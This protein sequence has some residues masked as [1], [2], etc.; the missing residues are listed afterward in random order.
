ELATGDGVLVLSDFTSLDG[1]PLTPAQL[2]AEYGLHEG[3]TLPVLEPAE[4]AAAEEY[5]ALITKHE[6]FWVER[7]SR[8]LSP[9]LS[10]LSPRRGG[11]RTAVLMRALPASL[12]RLHADNERQ[13]CALVSALAAYLARVSDGSCFDLALQQTRVAPS[14]TAA[15]AFS[16]I[17]PLR[18]DVQLEA[19]FASLVEDTRRELLTVTKRRTFA[20]D[21]VQRYQVLRGR[22][23]V[24]RGRLPIGVRL[25]ADEPPALVEGTQ[26]SLLRTADARRYAWA[27]DADAISAEAI[28][29]LAERFE[30]LLA[31]GLEDDR[32]PVAE[33]AI[34]PAAEREQLLTSW[35]RT[36]VV[37]P[38]TLCVHQLFEQQ[39]A[40]TPDARAVAFRAE[41]LSYRE[42]NQRANRVAEHLR[43]LGVE[44]ETLVGICVDRSLDMIIGLL[45]I[46]KAGGAY[47]PL[48]PVYPR[49]RLALML[50][51]ANAR[52]L[53][54]QRQWVDRLP[55]HSAQVLCIDELELRADGPC[56]DPSSSVQPDNL[57]YVIFTSGSTGRP[58]G[59]MVRHRN[60]VNFFAGMDAAL[61]TDPGVWLAV[62]SMSFDISV[63][64]LFWTLARG[65][66]VVIQE[67]S[68]RASLA[69]PAQVRRTHT[70]MDFGLF[71]FAADSGAAHAGNAYKLLLEG[72]KFA[73]SHDFSAVWT[74]E[75][76]FHAFGGLYPNPAVTTAALAT[77]TSRIQLR[78]GSVVLP[79]HNPLRVAE[80]WAVVDQ[81]S[82][83]R[84]G[85]SF[86]SGWHVNDFALMPE[87]FERRREIMLEHIDTVLKLWRGDK[88]T[89]LNGQGAPIEVSVLPRPVQTRPPLWIA[90]AGSVATFELAGKL[91]VNVLTNMLGQDLADLQ[92]KLAAYRAA[93]VEHGHEGPGHVSVMLHTFVCGDTDEAKRLV[94]KPFC[95]YLAS[96]FDLVKVA[97]WMFPAFRQPSVLA[98]RAAQPSASTTTVSDAGIDPS[99]YTPE[100]MAALLD[101]A[102]ER[103]F[104]SAGLFGTPERALAIVDQLKAIGANEVACLIDFG[105]DPDLVLASLPHLDRLR[106]LANPSVSSDSA[107]LASGGFSIGEQLRDRKIT[108]LQCTPSMARMLVADP[109]TLQGLRGLSRLLLG[110]EALPTD[111]V[112]QLL[113]VVGGEI[114]N[115]YG[116][117]ETTVWSTTS[118]VQSAGNIT[119]GRPIANTVTRILDARR[120]LLPI[121]A[122]GE[123]CIGGDGVVRGYLGRPDLTAERFIPDPFGREHDLLYRTG[124][125]ARYRADGTLEFRGRLDH[126]VKVSG[127]RIEL[128]E[129]ETVL[130]RHPAVRQCVVVAR[131]ED[132]P[133]QLVGYVVGAGPEAT[134]ATKVEA[135]GAAVREQNQERVSHWQS[136]WDQTYR[137]AVPGEHDARFNITGWNDS[138]TGEPIPR[139]QMREWLDAT[140]RRIR[141]FAPK[142]VLEIGCGTGMV[143]Y[144]VVPHVEHY[145]GVDLS[146][147]ALDT[148]RREL[149]ASESAKVTLLQQAA[150]TLDGVAE[151]TFDT[152]VINSVVQYFPDADYLVQVLRRASELVADGGRIF[153]GDVRSLEHLQAF[154]TWVELKQAPS[155][156]NAVEIAQRVE[157]RVANER[158]LVLSESFFHAL[159][160]S[161]PRVVAVDVRLKPGAAHNEMNCFRY[162]VTLHI[163]SALGA[164][165]V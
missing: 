82:G 47:V 66:E 24:A 78:A 132:G 9:T 93:R 83:G 88:V 109:M 157:Q 51:D 129:I 95:D 44:P 36:E 123:L 86:A 33:L 155:H 85:L 73:D 41:S 80:D 142:R 107:A 10:E 70:R 6:R 65:F 55:A 76:H 12:L 32:R 53:I 161:V 163:G 140:L 145:T 158:E 96:S 156:V 13:K 162:D 130:R 154:H 90:S 164:D 117:T 135:R 133:A 126:Q 81:L 141:A 25:D 52:V 165:G 114:L 152:V 45:G 63:L 2:R 37:Y 105:V 136:L 146:A 139:E 106:Q 108:H 77:I 57:A 18:C 128:E 28:A 71:Y 67:E 113:P 116:P 11:A 147:H 54:T 150:H 159:A 125:L 8:S 19:S 89:V 131:S 143:L 50:E 29:N 92:T 98:S 59:V 68:D 4:L 7:L 119:I 124:D 100:D 149:S 75:R 34:V 16:A 110:G 49:E 43:T 22:G 35:Q 122:E 42:L 97:P 148:I 153:V 120:Q 102:F 58:K 56:E 74:P 112:E 137:L 62:T 14:G 46:L 103:Y 134:P 31:A 26:L 72:A 138:A 84:V 39:V 40:K 99:V 121:G 20:R 21:V 101:H 5:D 111:L 91:G 94:R 118:R 151:K 104:D 69:D 23:P 87:N 115:M 15:E 30:V 60:V 61:G 17:T 160:G 3:G 48:D 1:A 79:L 38:A 144:G 27:Y 64:E 127:Y